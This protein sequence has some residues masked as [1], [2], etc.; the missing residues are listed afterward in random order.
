MVRQEL[1]EK[2]GN[3]QFFVATVGR[4]ER[5]IDIIELIATARAIGR[6]PFPL[7]KQY[8]DEASANQRRSARPP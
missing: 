2:L 6:D 1:A 7:M 5:R 8:L 3:P 4:G